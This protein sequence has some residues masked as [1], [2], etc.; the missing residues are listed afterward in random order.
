MLKIIKYAFA[1]VQNVKTCFRICALEVI[2]V[3]KQVLNRLV[4]IGIFLSFIAACT[5]TDSKIESAAKY[6]NWRLTAVDGEPVDNALNV[7]IQVIDAM[8]INGFGGCNRF[9]ASTQIADS[10]LQVSK[11][12]Q[13]YKVCALEV[14]NVERALINTLNSQP[15]IAIDNKQMTL[16]GLYSLTF[17]LK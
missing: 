15:D 8:H 13:S 14:M 16:Q 17:T 7:N 4:I 2:G 12:G 3:G 6:Q 10:K 1:A 9:F 11:L 5:S